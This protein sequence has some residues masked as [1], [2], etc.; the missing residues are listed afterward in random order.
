MWRYLARLGERV[1]S[2]SLVSSDDVSLT[3]ST[4]QRAGGVSDMA[5]GSSDEPVL[6][7]DDGTPS[8]SR[9][10]E[11]DSSSL[12][13][14]RKLDAR[15][16]VAEQRTRAGQSRAAITAHACSTSHSAGK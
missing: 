9:R 6:C 12:E 10:E 14:T 3:L 13:R 11:L 15:R 4:V 8:V 5:R 16:Q 1:R 2:G 7:S